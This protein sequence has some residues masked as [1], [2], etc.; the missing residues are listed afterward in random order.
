MGS[1]GVVVAEFAERA[2]PVAFSPR[3]RGAF[4]GG[5]NGEQ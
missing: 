4:G 5:L 1:M 3:V 2:W